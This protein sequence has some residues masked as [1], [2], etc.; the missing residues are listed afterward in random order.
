[1]APFEKDPIFQE[2]L[3]TFFKDDKEASEKFRVVLVMAIGC[4]EFARSRAQPIT[5]LYH[6]PLLKWPLITPLNK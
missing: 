6:I 3:K 4:L 2:G 1:M 5:D